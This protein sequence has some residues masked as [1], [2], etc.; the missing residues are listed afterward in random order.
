[1]GIITFTSS[2]TGTHGS[3]TVR[4][5]A[6]NFT[7]ISGTTQGV[8]NVN[9]T[10]TLSQGGVPQDR[11]A[12]VVASGRRA[13]GGTGIGNVA[14]MGITSAITNN[15][16]GDGTTTIYV[17]KPNSEILGNLQTLQFIILQ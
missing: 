11:Y 15:T 6:G 8:Y 12:T 13:T 4:M 17:G 9:Y 2:E 3:G 16:T 14:P 10:S 5:S 7:S 1:M